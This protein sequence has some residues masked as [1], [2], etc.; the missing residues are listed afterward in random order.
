MN[1][2]ALRHRY[3][4]G[5]HSPFAYKAVKEIL[6]PSSRYA[7]Y[8]EGRV[9]LALRQ[10]DMLGKMHRPMRT[11]AMASFRYACRRHSL[12]YTISASLPEQTRHAFAHA[13]RQ[14]CGDAVALAPDNPRQAD[15][16]VLQGADG[17][18][19]AEVLRKGDSAVVGLGFTPTAIAR[20]IPLCPSGTLFHSRSEFMFLPCPTMAFVD[21]AYL[22]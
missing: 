19:A 3:G 10:P 6:N 9:A 18:R 20:L 8:L 7:F 16:I 5:V 17:Q 14:G 2:P 1:Y 12:S 22:F 21:Y 13:I 11:L 4:F 15:F